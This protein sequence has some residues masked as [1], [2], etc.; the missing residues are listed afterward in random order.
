[1]CTIDT[2]KESNTPTCRKCDTGYVL[3]DGSCL[4]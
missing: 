1:M 4:S 3:D 2:D